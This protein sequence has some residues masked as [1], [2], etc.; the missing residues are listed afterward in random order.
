M[1]FTNVQAVI[2]SN[3]HCSQHVKISF[4]NPVQTIETNKLVTAIRRSFPTVQGIYL[5]GSF[6]TASASTASDVDIAVLLPHQI[7]KQNRNLYLSEL[8][9]ALEKQ[10]KRSVD[11]VNLRLVSTVLQQQVIEHG[12]LLDCQDQYALAEFEMLTSSFYQ[13]LNEERKEIL[14]DFWETARAYNV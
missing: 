11:L 2:Y 8:H 10:L 13:K 5:F 9:L 6:A 14:Q 4:V 1:A 12:Q 7:A 3:L